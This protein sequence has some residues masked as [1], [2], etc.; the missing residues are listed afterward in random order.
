MV[1]YRLTDWYLQ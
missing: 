1:T